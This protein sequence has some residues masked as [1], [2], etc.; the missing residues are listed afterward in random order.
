[1][2]YRPLCLLTLALAVLGCDDDPPAQSC[3]AG[4]PTDCAPLYEPT[5]ENVYDRTLLGSCAV[6]GSACHGSEGRT[7]ALRLG[8][9]ASAHAALMAYVTPGDAICSPLSTRLD[10]IGAGQMPP[11][12]PLNEAAK[13]S[14][15][16][17]ISNGAPP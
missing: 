4:D 12:G 9:P 5:F 11:G 1:M 2:K 7:S 17:W 6:G 10:G 8:D 13:C 14:I 15:R 16:Q 3:L